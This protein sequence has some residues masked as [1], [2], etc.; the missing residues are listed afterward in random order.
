VI[1]LEALKSLYLSSELWYF[2][3][4]QSDFFLRSDIC[5]LIKWYFLNRWM[6]WLFIFQVIFLES[7][8]EVTFYFSSDISW[9]IEVTFY[10]SSDISW[11]IEWSD[12]LFFKWYFLKHWSDLIYRVIFLE[13]L[14]SFC[15]YQYWNIEAT[16]TFFLFKEW[17]FF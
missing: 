9:N 16:G 4:H 7:L 17:Y 8:N 5:L 13:D 3:K 10:F 11:I 15:W 1:V 12:F 6:K 2:L 14:K